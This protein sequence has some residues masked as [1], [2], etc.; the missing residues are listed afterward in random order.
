MEY[1]AQNIDIP[2]WN[3]FPTLHTSGVSNDLKVLDAF[4]LLL[5]PWYPQPRHR[6]GFRGTGGGNRRRGITA[7]NCHRR[8]RSLQDRI[9]RGGYRGG[10][11]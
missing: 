2:K 3:I 10:G 5:L 4:L 1:S 11:Q 8:Y 9:R 7:G 6:G